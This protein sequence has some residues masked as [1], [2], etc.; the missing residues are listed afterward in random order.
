MSNGFEVIV[1][2]RQVS[3][4]AD[5]CVI[6]SSPLR[7]AGAT[8]NSLQW[9]QAYLTDTGI[10]TASQDATHTLNNIQHTPHKMLH[11]HH[12]ML[13][14]PH[15][16]LKSALLKLTPPLFHA[17]LLMIQMGNNIPWC[18]IS[19]KN[20]QGMLQY[21]LIER[22]FTRT[23]ILAHF[24]IYKFLILISLDCYLLILKRT[25]PGQVTIGE[26]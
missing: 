1:F 6:H 5:R 2:T 11:T 18:T 24:Q 12:K 10:H 26:Q 22:K 8:I 4:D 13:H 16:I 17:W 20:E 25:Y 9:R 7:F 23:S 3:G 21:A 15:K 19:K 14:T